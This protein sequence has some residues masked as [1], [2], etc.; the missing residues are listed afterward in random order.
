MD[1]DGVL[2]DGTIY[3][4]PGP[5]GAV[6]E[7]KAFDCRDGIAF[8]WLREAGIDTGI[9]TGRGGLAVRERARSVHMRYLV[10]GRTDKLASFEDILQDA[11]LAAEQVAYIGDGRDRPAAAEAGRP[12]RGTCR[13]PAGSPRVDSLADAR[14]RRPRRHPRRRRTAAQGSGEVGADAGAVPHLTPPGSGVK[15]A[16]A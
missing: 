8:K 5:D 16:A 10:E 3:F 6:V 12:G 9:V 7:T 11:G 2:T 1:C 15:T 4:I 13:R 14:E